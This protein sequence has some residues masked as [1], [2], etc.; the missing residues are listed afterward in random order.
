MLSNT[1]G[2]LARNADPLNESG[3]FFSRAPTAANAGE[4]AGAAH[5]ACGAVSENDRFQLPDSSRKKR[6]GRLA[7][8]TPT[9][10]SGN[11]DRQFDCKS[12]HLSSARYRVRLHV[13]E[14][15]RLSIPD[16]Y[17]LAGETYVGSLPLTVWSCAACERSAAPS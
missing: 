1:S 5:G 9:A 8:W 7:R 12:V 11:D 17:C 13:L 16:S 6:S 4:K 14:R 2:L 10:I 15:G 3:E